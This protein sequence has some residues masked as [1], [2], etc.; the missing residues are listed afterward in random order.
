MIKPSSYL[1]FT[2]DPETYSAET[3]ASLKRAYSYAAPTTV[4]AG[5]ANAISLRVKLP[6]R[7]YW[8][9]T[10]EE[11]TAIW[12]DVMVPWLFN[13]L[14]KLQETLQE[15]DNE[16]AKSYCGAIPFETLTL[17]LGGHLVTIPVVEDNLLVALDEAKAQ[18]G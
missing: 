4:E 7:P 12:N 14:R 18:R 1:T 5:D 8:D 11:E 6:G 16:N 10:S 3:E 17:D 13:K 9:A 15:Y 2:L